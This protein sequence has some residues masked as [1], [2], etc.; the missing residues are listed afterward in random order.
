MKLR[1]PGTCQE[2]SMHSVVSGL[3]WY[4][5]STT[6]TGTAQPMHEKEKKETDTW[7]IKFHESTLFKMKKLKVCELGDKIEPMIT[8]N[9]NYHRTLKCRDFCMSLRLLIDLNVR[10]IGDNLISYQSTN[11]WTGKTAA[12]IRA[13]FALVY[14]QSY[15]RQYDWRRVPRLYDKQVFIAFIKTEYYKTIRLWYLRLWTTAFTQ[16]TCNIPLYQIKQS[17]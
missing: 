14:L 9:S 11:G 10:G 2:K 4:S 8:D 1:K 6:A 13:T 3:Q 15:P 5:G 7:S 16:Q 17:W 12:F